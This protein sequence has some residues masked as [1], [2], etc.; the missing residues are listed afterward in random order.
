MGIE[1]RD[2]AYPLSLKGTRTVKADMIF[3]LTLGFNGISDGK[4]SQ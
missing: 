2:N 4:N 3:S 1:F